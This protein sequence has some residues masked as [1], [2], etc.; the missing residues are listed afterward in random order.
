MVVYP[1]VILDTLNAKNHRWLIALAVNRLN[2]G[3]FN[4][5]GEITLT[6]NQTTTDLI[7]AR[8][9]PY[10]FVQF[11]PLTAN[12]AMELNAGTMY[13]LEADRGAGKFTVTHANNAQADRTFNYLIIG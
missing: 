9:Q 3:K 13:V 11:D 4:A 7:D 5:T 8:L 12:A 2:Q 10:S 6:P 1:Y